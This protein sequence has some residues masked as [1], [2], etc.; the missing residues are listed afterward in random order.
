MNQSHDISTHGSAL[1]QHLAAED[2][3]A[4]FDSFRDQRQQLLVSEDIT[5]DDV[6]SAMDWIMTAANTAGDEAM[7]LMANALNTGNATAF[8]EAFKAQLDQ[9]RQDRA[10]AQVLDE[11]A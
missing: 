1:A 10:F 3:S 6:Y 9:N 5:A 8:F 4:A 2:R 7:A 11:V